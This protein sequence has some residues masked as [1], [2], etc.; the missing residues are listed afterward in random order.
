MNVSSNQLLIQ[1]SGYDPAGNLSQIGAYT[2]V[3]DGENRMVSSALNGST[4]YVYDGEGH[5][6]Q[7]LS[8][9]QTTNFVYDAS[10][11]LAAEYSNVAPA[12]GGTEYL[13]ADHLGSTRMVTNTQAIYA[14]GKTPPRSISESTRLP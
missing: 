6:V 11:Q 3:Y 10:G 5:R 8:G 2:F 1:N 12:D 14:D 13:T 9:S 4:T 7:K